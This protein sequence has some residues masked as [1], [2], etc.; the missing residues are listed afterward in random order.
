MDA[1]TI[2][3]ITISAGTRTVVV[4]CRGK[5]T[6]AVDGNYNKVKILNF[7]DG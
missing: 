5:T 2:Y 1:G 4:H 7:A 3:L 6:V